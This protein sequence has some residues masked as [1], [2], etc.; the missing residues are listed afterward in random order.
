MN[1]NPQSFNISNSSNFYPSLAIQNIH[2]QNHLPFIGNYSSFPI[3]IPIYQSYQTVYNPYPSYHTPSFANYP[4]YPTY[5]TYQAYQAYTP[6][7]CSGM[8]FSERS[9]SSISFG[10]IYIQPVPNIQF[11]D[12]FNMPIKK[13]NFYENLNLEKIAQLVPNGFTAGILEPEIDPR[14]NKLKICNSVSLREIPSKIWIRNGDNLVE[15][16]N[17]LLKK[18]PQ[19]SDQ[20]LD[21]SPIIT[22]RT[23]TSEDSFLYQPEMP[24]LSSYRLPLPTI[25]K[26]LKRLTEST[27]TFKKITDLED[28]ILKTSSCRKNLLTSQHNELTSIS[29]STTPSSLTLSISPSPPSTTINLKLEIMTP[30][31]KMVNGGLEKYELGSKFIFRFVAKP[32]LTGKAI[33][34]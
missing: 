21:S 7:Y 16:P 34:C 2:Y 20:N 29:D 19:I 31:E 4:T 18:D 26:A 25:M 3:H 8:E 23:I 24:F 5:P 9:N 12:S 22:P 30:E 14:N 28:E 6:N 11:T 10:Q 17:H 32:E 27:K 15:V 13:Y 1:Y 33:L